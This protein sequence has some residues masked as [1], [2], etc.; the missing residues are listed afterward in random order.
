[1]EMEMEMETAAEGNRDPEGRDR[2][3]RSVRV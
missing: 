2:I 3:I 1:M